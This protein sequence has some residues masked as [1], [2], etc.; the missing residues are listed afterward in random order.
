MAKKTIPGGGL[1]VTAAVVAGGFG[2]LTAGGTKAAA[3]ALGTKKAVDDENEE[4]ESN[5]P[6]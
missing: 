3:V 1:D 4:G 5:F 2:A 6:R